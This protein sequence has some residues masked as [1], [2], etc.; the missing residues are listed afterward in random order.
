[1][2]GFL[3]VC[4]PDAAR[5]PFGDTQIKGC[6]GRVDP[7]DISPRKPLHFASDGLSLV[8]MNPMDGLLVDHDCVC[9]GYLVDPFVDWWETGRE[10]PDGAYAI[11]RHDAE[12]LQLVTDDT[13][14]RTI[15]YVGGERFF[16]ASTS[17][18]ALIG[19]LGSFELN[20]GAAAWMLSSGFLGPT[21]SWD[22]RLRPLAPN[23]RL[24]LDRHNWLVS[25]D[26][27]PNRFVPLD[28]PVAEHRR[29]LLAAMSHACSSPQLD[30]QKW[31]LPL[32]GG[33]DSRGLLLALLHVGHRPTCVTWGWASH[34]DVP[35]NDVT[36][37]IELTGRLGVSHEFIPLDRS[38]A[39]P[40]DA[41]GHFLRAGEGRADLFQAY[42]DGM[43]MWRGFYER[44]ITGVIRG[45]ESFGWRP[46][47]TE[48]EARKGQ[49][50]MLCDYPPD[51]LVRRFE[52]PAQEWPDYLHKEPME[53]CTAY[54]DRLGLDW[55]VACT[56][57]PLNQLKCAYVEVADP[58]LSA[59]VLRVVRALPDSLRTDKALFRQVVASIS[60]DV[61]IATVGGFP[62]PGFLK[63]PEVL[64]EV[65]DEL[66]TP[67]AAAILG[68]DALAALVRRLARPTGAPSADSRRRDWQAFAGEHVPWRVAA[69]LRLFVGRPWLTPEMLGFRAYI[70]SRMATILEEDACEGRA[71]R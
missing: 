32:S 51:H 64:H 24:T 39:S 1:M 26:R 58:F 62:G 54:S 4:W 57:A 53:T 52:M 8:V 16:A 35:G 37:A 18:R 48:R 61:P 38:M 17:Q 27:S 70:V 23:A 41:V 66:S 28:L 10:S 44:G 40:R 22:V 19:L 2:S 9:L 49:A 21:T 42:T 5:P 25:V 68:Q 31:L 43:R 11:C 47:V 60:P 36:V 45:E 69:W 29:R 6:T 13:G 71:L 65:I 59:S 46:V 34:R 12:R 20:L 30:D 3:V 15:W 33:V 55:E 50:Y 56:F 7:D 14:S 63:S 67:H